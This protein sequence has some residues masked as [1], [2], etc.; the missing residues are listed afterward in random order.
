MR[1]ILGAAILLGVYVGLPVAAHG[2]NGLLVVALALALVGLLILA[3]W[4]L[5]V[6]R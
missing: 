4:L 1:K 6:D 3:V 2:W 5:G